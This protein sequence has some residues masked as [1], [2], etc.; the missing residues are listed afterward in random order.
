[1][2]QT[3]VRSGQLAAIPQSKVTSLTSDLSAIN[4][5]L[6]GL[7]K[8]GR[9]RVATTGNITI[10][11]ALNNGDTLN[12]V[13]L[14]TGDYVLVKNQ[15]AP[16]ENGIYIVGATPARVAEFDSFDEHSGALVAVTEGT[17]N[18][19]TLWFC[20]VNAG[21]TLNTTAIT[22]T[23]LDVSGGSSETVVTR[24]T[25][26]GTVDG[27]NDEFELA[28]NPVSGSEQVFVNGIL[29]DAGSGNDYQIASTT[30]TFESGAIPQTGDKVR[31]SYRY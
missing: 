9:C 29:Q 2:A 19:D 6:T 3:A 27:T 4:T 11:T 20:P 16:E 26:S 8:K 23:Q 5:A 30:I 21:G 1:M 12:G 25:P 28:H 18:A 17:T 13:T 24:E 14:A 31:V 7:G 22:F 15:T 10:S